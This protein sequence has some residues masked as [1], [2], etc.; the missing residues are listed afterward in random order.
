MPKETR[1][2]FWSPA[3]RFAENIL[4]PIGLV[5]APDRFDI[6]LSAQPGTGGDARRNAAGEHRNSG[7]CW[8]SAANYLGDYGRQ[9]HDYMVLKAK[10]PPP[11]RRA[12]TCVKRAEVH[13]GL[14]FR[15]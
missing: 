8:S 12:L 10:L 2:R 6:A 3:R 4:S 14:Y 15:G 13:D 1:I 7:L 5:A 11:V 9:R